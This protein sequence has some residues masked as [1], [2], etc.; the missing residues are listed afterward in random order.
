MAKHKTQG[1]VSAGRRKLSNQDKVEAVCW[2]VFDHL[3]TPEPYWE[4]LEQRR[5]GIACLAAIAVTLAHPVRMLDVM[6]FE[7]KGRKHT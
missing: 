4:L 3:R 7:I 1:R 5:F 6:I 2:N